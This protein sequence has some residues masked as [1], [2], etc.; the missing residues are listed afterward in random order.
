MCTCSINEEGQRVV[1][2]LCAS[3]QIEALNTS[4]PGQVERSSRM[5]T[6]QQCADLTLA[7]T[8]FFAQLQLSVQAGGQK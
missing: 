8:D 2:D 6:S 7:V 5:L 4:A 3:E 1:C